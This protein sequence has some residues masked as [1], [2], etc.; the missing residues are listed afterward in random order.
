MDL[1]LLVVAADEG[2]MPQTKEHIDIL[3]QLGLKKS[4]LVLNK[5]D[6]VDEEWLELV[7]EDIR[8]ELKGTF[9][10][11]APVA[12]VSAVTGAGL[13]H[14]ID[15]IE[16]MTDDEVEERD[17]N[18]IPRLPV[19]RVFSLSG[20]GTIVTGTLISGQISKEDQLQLFPLER[21]CKIHS[22]QVHGENVERCGA[23]QRV[24]INLSN[25]KKKE[26][27]RGCVLAPVGSMKNT[28]M[29]D[30]RLNVLASSLRVIGN[31]TR[32]H[33][34]TGTSEVLCRAVLLD[35]EELGP[36]ESG[37][38]QLRLEEEIAVRRG[39]KFIVR[40]YSP[41][42]TIGGGEVL[43]AN[44]SK[45]KRF[46][47]ETLRE[48]Q[49]K[50]EGSHGD[51]IE[52]LIREHSHTAISATEIAKLTALS[53][54]EVLEVTAV[55]KD[56]QKISEFSLKKDSWFWHTGF[57]AG[58]KQAIAQELE[59]FHKDNPYK[60]GKKKSELRMTHLPGVK[61][62]IFDAFIQQLEAAGVIGRTDERIRLPEFTIVRDDTYRRIETR[63]KKAFH[64][65]AY[66]FVRFSEIDFGD[67]PPEMVEDILQLLIEDGEVVKISPEF[68]SLTEIIQEA[69]ELVKAKL[70]QDGII[71]IA[72][73]RDLLQTSR[74]SAKPLLEYLDG[75]KITK[76]N[77]TESERVA[78]V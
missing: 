30:V 43:E 76:R 71:T 23:G 40:F 74:K 10:A 3:S 62:N 54:E 34:F 58:I 2:I 47:Q 35:A 42:E 65:A 38:V 51:A 33:L 41:M 46:D 22:I 57:E 4:I 73:L 39:D 32:L 20:F 1:V 25:I 12:E 28:M 9:F 6:L 50:E 49:M 56:E 13:P 29:L 36:G 72:E 78:Y 24:A 48:L 64:R 44:P 77:G 15:L 75:R 7:K 31:R 67:Q 17:I 14:L 5:C 11:T 66:D 52:L 8:E 27:K 55:L 70:Q 59:Q 18:T 61:Q 53:R 68:Y 26:I 69:E 21:E 63:M 16:Q 60:Y 37:Y 19:D 45:K